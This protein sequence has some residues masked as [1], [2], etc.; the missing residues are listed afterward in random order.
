M[1][2]FSFLFLFGILFIAFNVDAQ[3]AINPSEI[4]VEGITS[5]DIDIVGHSFIENNTEVSGSFT[6]QRTIVELSEGWTTAVC[7]PNLC[8]L[9]G[10]NTAAFNLDAGA[11]GT[12]DVHVYP[13]GFEGAAIV[14]V[15]V[16]ETANPDNATVGTYYFNQGTNGVAERFS[17]AVKVYP[18]P[19]QDWI[20]IDNA[21]NNVVTAD[22]YDINGKMVLSSTVN[23]N[24]RLSIQELPAGNY[25]LKMMDISGDIISTNHLVKN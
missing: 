24:Q 22:L 25:I 23:G 18:N 15:E 2:K 10:T 4:Y 11:S 13:N 20:I 1:K 14:E 17:E 16:Y 21:D 3:L 8:Y 5:A 6:W 9:T 19:T 7:D 12:M